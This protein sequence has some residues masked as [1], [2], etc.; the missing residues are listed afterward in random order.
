MP[1]VT[2]VLSY[3]QNSEN[4][5]PMLLIEVP[6]TLGRT[7]QGYQHGGVQEGRERICEETLG[8]AVWLFGIKAFNKVGDFIGEK[9]L[10]LKELGTDVG[11]D[12][13]RDPFSHVKDKKALTAGFKFTKIA[14]ATILGVIAMGGAVPAL[15]KAMTNAFREQQNLPPIPDKN[16]EYKQGLADKIVR[17]FINTDKKTAPEPKNNPDNGDLFSNS[18]YVNIN[19]FV[20]KAKSSGNIS[21]KGGGELLNGILHASHNL[22][23]DNAW[24]LLSSDVGMLAGRVG[25]SRNSKEAIEYGFRDSVSSFFYIFAAP[26]F[27]S[28]L[29][30]L[31]NTPDIH[32]KGAEATGEMLKNVLKGANLSQSGVSNTYFSSSIMSNEELNALTSNIKFKD[33]GTIW[34]DEFNRQTGNLFSDKAQKM[35]LLQPQLL[36]ESGVR[37]SVLSK[38][39]VQDIMSNSHTSD[40]EF[41]KSAISSVTDG[42]SDNVRSFVSRSSLEKIRNSFDEY[43]FGLERFAKDKAQNG[44]INDEIID[45]YTKHLNRKNLCFHMLGVGFAIFGLAYLIPKLQYVV[46][47]MLTGTKG[48]NL[49]SDNNQNKNLTA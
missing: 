15:K 41:L 16:G 42:K 4:T 32:P 21:F 38:R 31:T 9:I 6:T 30:K 33:N 20:E 7:Y 35:S 34:L 12:S 22:E 47:D 13:L 39:Q 37:A 49:S 17:F 23:N 44:V 27:S 29:R 46:S 1:S 19:Q 36:N 25:T 10:G 26:I 28:G 43:I 2:P 40:P 48:Y 24:R 8:A 3:L 5:L 14:T 18:N 45:K 11:K